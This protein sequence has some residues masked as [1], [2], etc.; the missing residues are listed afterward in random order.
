MKRIVAGIYCLLF[1]LN[2][3]HAQKKSVLLEPQTRKINQG[4]PLPSQSSFD[5]QVPVGREIGIITINVFRGNKPSDVIEKTYW[6]RAVYF[7]GEVAE[8]PLDVRLHNNSKYG[9]DV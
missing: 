1:V 6:T 7:K 5:I 2:C 9:F 3:V 4:E 8:L